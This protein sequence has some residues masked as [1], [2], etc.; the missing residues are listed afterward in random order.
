VNKSTFEY[1]PLAKGTYTAMLW[2]TLV[3]LAI[4]PFLLIIYMPLLL[5]LGLGL[6]PFLIQTGLAEKYQALSAKRMD[7]LNNKL[8]QGY[9]ARNAERINKRDKHLNEMRNKLQPRD[10]N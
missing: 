7:K 8:K 6:K 2:F 10:K 5:F 3:V 1:S 4:N 9:D